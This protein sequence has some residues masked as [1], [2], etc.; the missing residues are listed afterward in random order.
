MLYIIT[1]MMWWYIIIQSEESRRTWADNEHDRAF[2]SLSSSPLVLGYLHRM[3][4]GS[5]DTFILHVLYANLRGLHGVLIV[6]CGARTGGGKRGVIRCAFCLMVW[7]RWYLGVVDCI[8]MDK[9]IET[10]DG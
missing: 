8:F 5:R 1:R 7:F 9:Y 2:L 6:L 3:V 10:F 4:H